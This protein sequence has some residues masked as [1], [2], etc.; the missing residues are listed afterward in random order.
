[1]AAADYEP[2][3]RKDI[4]VERDFTRV[5]V[6]LKMIDRNERQIIGDAK[7]LSRRKTDQKRSGGAPAR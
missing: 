7:R 2:D 6:C 5:N 4:L 1:M 3:A